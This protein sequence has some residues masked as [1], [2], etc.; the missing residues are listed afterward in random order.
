MANEPI[1]PVSG[2]PATSVVDTQKL[3]DF[4]LSVMKA[5]LDISMENTRGD[6]GRTVASKFEKRFT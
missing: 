3:Q 6:Y 1:T 2:G 4:N 5:Q